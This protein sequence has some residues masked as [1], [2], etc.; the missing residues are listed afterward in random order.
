MFQQKEWNNRQSQ[1]PL[2]RRLVSTTE[3][4]IYD[5][6]RAEGTITNPG[7][8]IDAE[9]LN[10][11]EQRIADS[12]NPLSSDVI[13][14]AYQAVIQATNTANTVSSDLIEKRD[15]GYFNGPQGPQGPQGIQGPQGP[16]GSQGPEGPQGI[17]GPKGE[18]GISATTDGYFTLYINENG[19]LIAQYPDNASPPPLSLNENG[20]LIYTIS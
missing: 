5:I 7:D 4:N 6:I 1:Y 16:E 13:D 18:S 14:S 10:D 11:L 19:D 15:N 17:Q 12:V 9:N 20:D 8:P 2:R 3:P